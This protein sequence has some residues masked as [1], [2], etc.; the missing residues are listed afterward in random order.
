MGPGD[1]PG[2]RGH[3]E[4]PRRLNSAGTIHESPGAHR[5]N[6]S[7]SSRA[8]SPPPCITA[9]NTGHRC[10]VPI[11]SHRCRISGNPGKFSTH[12][13]PREF[14]SRRAVNRCGIHRPP[15]RAS[16]PTPIHRELRPQS[17]FSHRHTNSGSTEYGL[18]HLIRGRVDAMTGTASGARDRHD[19]RAQPPERTTSAAPPFHLRFGRNHP[20]S[21]R[22][23]TCGRTPDPPG[24]PRS[25]P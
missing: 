16:V 4:I 15:R 21:H 22:I 23:S 1:H 25:R 24:H 5:S 2:R 3:R 7:R 11:I 13:D 10:R 14:R 9:A 20:A 19:R 8:N 12:G 17:K 6:C 18:A